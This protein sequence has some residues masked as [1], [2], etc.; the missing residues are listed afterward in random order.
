MRTDQESQTQI[1]RQLRL[2]KTPHATL[3]LCTALLMGW[4]TFDLVWSQMGIS[5]MEEKY[6]YTLLLLIHLINGS[7][8]TER[9]EGSF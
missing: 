3:C 1:P 6:I 4:Y 9:R 2:G 8:L 5:Q 7:L